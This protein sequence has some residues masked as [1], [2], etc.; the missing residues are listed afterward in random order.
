M[1]PA[2]SGCRQGC[3]SGHDGGLAARLRLWP[4]GATAEERRNDMESPTNPASVPPGRWSRWRKPARRWAVL[5]AA[6]AAIMIA[7]TGVALATVPD[8][9]GVFHGCYA[10]HGGELRIIDPSAGQQCKKDETAVSWNQTGP[11]GPQGAAGPQGPEGNTGPAGP[12]GPQGPK[13]DTGT[14]GPTGP[15][16]PAG[17]AGPV[18]GAPPHPP[19]GAARPDP[20]VT[21]ARPGRRAP[22]GCRVT[23]RMR[24]SSRCHP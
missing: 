16:G 23:S 13:G 8:G 11:A 4:R 9:T 15:A 24:F 19:A 6:T 2:L 14:P 1:S 21:P 5:S 7:G 10:K 20:R 22:R 3:V 18:G 12:A 17:T